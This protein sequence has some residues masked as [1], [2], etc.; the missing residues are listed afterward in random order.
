MTRLSVFL[1]YC[2]YVGC[3]ILFPPHCLIHVCGLMKYYVTNLL[4][5]PGFLDDFFV[6]LSSVAADCLQAGT[7][8]DLQSFLFV[9]HRVAIT[10]KCPFCC[11]NLN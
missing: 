6:I 10:L 2:M 5:H 1:K 9:I 8:T 7:L 11:C 3:V 4:T